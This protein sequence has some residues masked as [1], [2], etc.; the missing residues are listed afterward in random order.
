[1]FAGLLGFFLAWLLYYR[2]PQLP[3]QIAAGLGGLYQAVV[4]KYYID[5]LY[6]TLFVKPLIAGSALILWHGIDQDVIDAALDNSAAWRARSFRFG[7]AH[8]VRQ[9]AL[10]RGMGGSRG[11]RGDRLHDLDGNAMNTG[12][13]WSPVILTLVTFIPLAGALLLLLLP[14]RDR[15]IRVFSLVVSLLTFVLSL[16]LPVHFHRAQAG[17]PV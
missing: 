10:L 4:H 2:N 11:R 7:A 15:D 14:R 6:A 1:M 17:F 9:P 3:Q 5:E 13:H 16:H 8:A 12:L